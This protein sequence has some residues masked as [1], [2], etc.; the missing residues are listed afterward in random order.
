MFRLV[1]F[2][3]ASA[4]L[5]AEPQA[6]DILKQVGET[7]AHLTA[8]HLVAA[9][10][11][12]IS[13]RG[14]AATSDADFEYA[15]TAQGRFRA[16]MRKGP[17]E[18]LAVSDGSTTWKALPREK[19]WAKTQT[20]ALGDDDE[21][22]PAAA[23]RQPQDLREIIGRDM[24]TRYVAIVR[25][26]EEPEYVKDE[27]CSVGGE[28]VPCYVLR[29]RI[30]QR[31]HDVWIDQRRFLIVRDVQTGPRA[32]GS[33]NAQERV[34][35]RLKRIETNEHVPPSVFEFKPDPKWTEVEMLVLPEE[36]RIS[37]AGQ[38]AAGFSLKSLDGET[39]SLSDYRGKVLV[40]DFWATWCP[41][42]RQELPIL[43]KLRTEYAGKV[44]FVGVNNEDARTIRD[45]LKS[46]H[47]DLEVLV[48][49]KREVYRRYGVRSIP[50]LL[51][52]DSHG[53]IRQHLIGARSEAELRLAI[54][55]AMG[56]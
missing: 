23:G 22:Q 35:T 55:A 24:V 8:V 26:A 14:A 21:E 50:T 12:E 30:G 27:N 51:V 45:F 25:Y 4:A 36:Q 38:N 6:A 1:S 53:V 31:K 42:C 9:R 5:A 13:L 2:L 33:V 3:C 18:A 17:V 56:S 44:E 37:L 16:W 32:A 54:A 20:A 34:E 10:H 46:R 11:T 49:G 7:Y 48:D 39:R 52:I 15:S 41:P 28:K 29:L 40:V 43:N 19:Q 47:F